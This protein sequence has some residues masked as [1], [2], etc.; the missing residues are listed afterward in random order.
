MPRK[1]YKSII[2]ITVLSEDKPV[3]SLDLLDINYLIT[4]GDCS[5][6][7]EIKEEK[8]VSPQEMARLLIEQSSEPEFFNLDEDGKDL[9]GMED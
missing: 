4:F 9:D 1:F 2:E 8:E 5:G 7:V 3:E 6:K